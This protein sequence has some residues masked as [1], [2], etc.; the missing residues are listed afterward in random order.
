M[1]IASFATAGAFSGER[2]GT[3]GL[4]PL[5]QADDDLVARLERLPV[6][7]AHFGHAPVGQ[8]G[9]DVDLLVV[10]LVDDAPNPR[11]GRS[12]RRIRGREA[13]RRLAYSQDI[14]GFADLDVE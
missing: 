14:G 2:Q 5:A 6:F 4:D 8:T 3:F 9:L 7:R 1:M 10:T 12:F 11:S 13:Q